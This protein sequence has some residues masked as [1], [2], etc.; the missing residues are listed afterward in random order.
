MKLGMTMAGVAVAMAVLGSTGVADA[1]GEG[2]MI[3]K[4]LVLAHG[5]D[6]REPQEATTRFKRSDDRVYAFVEVANTADDGTISVV[7]QP[8]SGSSLAEIPLEVKKSSRFRTWAFTRKAHDV[9]QWGVTIRDEKGR[10]LA[11]E[12]FTVE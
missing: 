4:R 2:K 8:P 7:F 1:K 3:V 10:V 11:K 6:S 12:T 5:V 9:G